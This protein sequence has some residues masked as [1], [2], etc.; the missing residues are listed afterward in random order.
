MYGKRFFIWAGYPPAAAQAAQSAYPRSVGGAANADGCTS[1]KAW[2]S[3]R[4]R[5]CVVFAGPN[6][7]ADP[8]GA[9]SRLPAR[10]RTPLH[11]WPESAWRLSTGPACDRQSS[12][13]R[14][15]GDGRRGQLRRALCCYW[16]NPRCPRSAGFHGDQAACHAGRDLWR[17]GL[18]DPQRRSRGLERRAGALAVRGLAV[19]P[20]CTRQPVT[21]QTAMAG[22]ALSG[23]GSPAGA[24]D[25]TI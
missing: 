22:G 11:P 12:A 9:G 2:R 21:G 24:V 23:T 1:G 14:S 10:K 13:R 5:V 4:G 6:H 25:C 16:R 17:I 19:A 3:G 7:W 8:L 20:K 15:L 18:P